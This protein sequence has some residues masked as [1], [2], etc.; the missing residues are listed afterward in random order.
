MPC[1]HGASRARFPPAGCCLRCCHASDP[2]SAWPAAG[3]RRRPAPR[4]DRGIGSTPSRGGRELPMSPE[5]VN[6]PRPGDRMS[7][8]VRRPVV[9]LVLWAVLLVGIA[10]T[11][12]LL[13]P[14]LNDSFSLAGVQS[15]TA[16]ELL[17][18]LADGKTSDA[19][20]RVVW[21]P[22]SGSATDAAVV[23]AVRPAL[24]RIADLSFITCVRGPSGISLG[25]ACTGGPAGRPARRGRQG[26][27]RQDRL[28][29]EDPGGRRAGR[30]RTGAEARAAGEGRPRHA[31]GRG[32]RA[33]PAGPAR[34]GSAGH[35]RGAARPDSRAV[36]HARGHH[37]RRGGRR[38]RRGRRPRQARQPA[39]GHAEEDRGRRPRPRSRRSPRS[40]PPRWARSSSSWPSSRPPSRRT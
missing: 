38:A 35:A 5:R 30:A 13:R 10:T 27:R 12:V 1:L 26:D 29:A 24:T 2:A 16:Q 28:D 22:Q 25:R 14:S 33:A 37:E 34:T 17:E 8:A 21:S 3:G 32:S 15:T 4:M 23:A 31:R 20:A 19:S 36:A 40:C 9:A 6:A 7:W 11:A 18:S 39:A